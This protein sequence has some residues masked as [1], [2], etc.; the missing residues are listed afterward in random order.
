[1]QNG[2]MLSIVSVPDIVWSV[3]A[4]AECTCGATAGKARRK[5]TARLIAV[6]GVQGMMQP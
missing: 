6:R 5:E 4:A 2:L 3:I 1:M